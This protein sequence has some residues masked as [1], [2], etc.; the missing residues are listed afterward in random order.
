MSNHKIEIVD[1]VILSYWQRIT[2][3]LNVTVFVRTAAI[4]LADI[5]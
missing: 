1:L 2:L 5:T 4:V 3:S